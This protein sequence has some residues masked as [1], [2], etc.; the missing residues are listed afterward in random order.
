MEDE[1]NGDDG[2]NVDGKVDDGDEDLSYANQ[3]SWGYESD[4][5]SEG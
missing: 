5:N 3:I 1:S 2:D 4:D